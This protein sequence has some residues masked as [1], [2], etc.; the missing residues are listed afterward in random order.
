M[1]GFGTIW[2]LRGIEG[3][4]LLVGAWI[5]FESLRA[6]SR[7]R[8]GSLALLGI[9]FVIVTVASGIAGVLYE[10]TTHDLLT[11]WTV[12]AIVDFL[13]FSL[14]L[15]SILRRAGPT[16]ISEVTEDP[17]VDLGEPAQERQVPERRV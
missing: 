9:G 7:S 11:A 17:V 16:P 12:S 13:G 1:T 5:A 14:I 4:T 3:L 15:Y 6:Y 10:V 2:V 8:E